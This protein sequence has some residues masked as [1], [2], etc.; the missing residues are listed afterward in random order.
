MSN[1]DVAPAVAS[2]VSRHLAAHLA[3]DRAEAI[4][5]VL[6]DGLGAGIDAA[7]L[8]RELAIARIREALIASGAGRE[9][10]DAV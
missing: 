9:R 2:L 7:T 10:V 5:L 4:R 3:G 1:L 8:P 6:D